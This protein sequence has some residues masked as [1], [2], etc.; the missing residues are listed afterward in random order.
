MKQAKQPKDKIK[1]DY[2]F[3]MM[4]MYFYSKGRCHEGAFM[5]H[6]GLEKLGY[7]VKLK[8]GVYIYQDNKTKHSWV[9]YNGRILETDTKQLGINKTDLERFRIIEDKKIIKRYVE[10]PID[11]NLNINPQQFKRVIEDYVNIIKNDKNKR[12][13]LNIDVDKTKRE[14]EENI[15]GEKCQ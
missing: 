6:K 1:L 12:F 11:F 3:L 2:T 15:G 5:L 10:F 14:V 13:D 7:D 4:R 8:H 9:E